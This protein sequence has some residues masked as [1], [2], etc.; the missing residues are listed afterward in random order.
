MDIESPFAGPPEDT[1]EGILRASFIVLERYGYSGLTM[2][3]I[4]EEAGIEKASVYHYY[5]DK[6]SLLLALVDYVI[7]EMKYRTVQ[8]EDAD[9]LQQLRCFIDQIVF[10]RQINGEPTGFSPPSE[11][12]LRVF[13]QIRAQATHD[14]AYREKITEI[15]RLQ[16]DHIRDVIQAGIDSGQFADVDAECVASVVSTLLIGVFSRR[17]TTNAD[18]E[19]VR[20]AIHAYLETVLAD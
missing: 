8:R 6:D 11:E 1:R 3:R 15:T 7:E 13:I 20:E 17:V 4:A 14:D 10:G 18:V 9:P 12:T 19:P 2:S 16:Q 5:S